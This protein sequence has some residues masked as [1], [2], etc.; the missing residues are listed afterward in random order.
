MRNCIYDTV[1][2]LYP[3][4]KH[5]TQ[6]R[7]TVCLHSNKGSR[8]YSANLAL[9]SFRLTDALQFMLQMPLCLIPL[10][11]SSHLSEDQER[12][13]RTTDLRQR[14]LTEVRAGLCMIKGEPLDLLYFP[15]W[16]KSKQRKRCKNKEERHLSVKR[17]I[18]PARFLP[19]YMN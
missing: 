10:C 18:T 6:P 7:L 15:K 2:L 11:Y 3:R 12:K 17:S 5:G 13:R 9:L 16:T 19:S 4:P 1:T 8:V 14:V